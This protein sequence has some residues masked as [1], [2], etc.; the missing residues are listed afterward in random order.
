M[1][2]NFVLLIERP[3]VVVHRSEATIH[4]QVERTDVPRLVARQV[5]Y[6]IGDV[7]GHRIDALEVGLAADECQEVLERVI[8]ALA[9]G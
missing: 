2:D 6:G 8:S 7:F 5:E 3:Q 4:H 9:L 1:A